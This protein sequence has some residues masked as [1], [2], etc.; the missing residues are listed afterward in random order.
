MVHAAAE[1]AG[2]PVN[3]ISLLMVGI[4]APLLV[5]PL[6]ILWGQRELSY[7]ELAAMIL[8]LIIHGCRN[9]NPARTAKKYGVLRR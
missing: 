9:Q 8:R 1:S 6:M 5:V 3:D 7:D 2:I 4:A